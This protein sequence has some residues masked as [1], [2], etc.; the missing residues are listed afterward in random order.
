MMGVI[1]L[2][3][4]MFRHRSKR[5]IPFFPFWFT[6]AYTDN[7]IERRDDKGEKENGQHPRDHAGR[8]AFLIEHV[9]QGRE[10]KNTR[11]DDQKVGTDEL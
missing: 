8:R 3:R 1:H 10:E 7:K 5:D 11:Q 6:F 4:E 9:A 2:K